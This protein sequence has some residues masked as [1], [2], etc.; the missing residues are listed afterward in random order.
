[1]T[2]SRSDFPHLKPGIIIFVCALACGGAALLFSKSHVASTQQSQ[3]AA[4]RGLNE[5]QRQLADARN[6]LSA[7]QDDQKNIAAYAKEYARMVDRN[8][9]GNEQR[10]DWIE[11]LDNIRRQR[12]VLNATYTIAPQHPYTPA[13]ALENGN[14]DLSLSPVSLHLDLLH[15][16]QLVAFFDA[17]RSDMKGWFMLDHCA[18]SRS[19][20]A[21]E[22]AGAAQLKAECTGGW[23]TLKNRNQK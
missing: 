21:F 19:G 23:L 9:I 12:R 11:G 4:Q 13:P 5:A 2:F 18:L 17:L 7:A 1:M 22:D 10:L 16:R 14:F 15:E 3:Q 6:R 20:A 8:I